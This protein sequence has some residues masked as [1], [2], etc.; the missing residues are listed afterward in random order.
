MCQHE[1]PGALSADDEVAAHLADLC[2][3]SDSVA[4]LSMDQDSGDD[5]PTR[6]LTVIKF[7]LRSRSLLVARIVSLDCLTPRPQRLAMATR[8]LVPHNATHSIPSLR[9]RREP[10]WGVNMETV[11]VQG[12]VRRF[13]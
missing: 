5:H 2:S 7:L 4:G 9:N 11:D 12:L 10:S 8:I 6:L 3:A 1:I 13:V